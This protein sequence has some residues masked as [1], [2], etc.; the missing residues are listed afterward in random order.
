[1][2]LRQ[3]RV[4]YAVETGSDSIARDLAKFNFHMG[5]DCTIEELK[6]GLIEDFLRVTHANPIPIKNF[7]NYVFRQGYTSID[8]STKLVDIKFKPRPYPK[9]PY[10]LSLVV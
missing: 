6:I 8:L 10:P 4:S 9:V 2:D 5:S 1:M 3:V 7:L